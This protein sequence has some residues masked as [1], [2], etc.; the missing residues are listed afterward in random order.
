MLSSNLERQGVNLAIDAN[1]AYFDVTNRRVGVNTS[2]PNY[3]LDVNG[4]ANFGS[5]ITVLGVSTF[6]N[7]TAGNITVSG[8]INISGNTN[9]ITGN[10]GSFFGNAAGFGALYAGIS[11]GYVPDPQ[12]IQQST[13]NFNGYAGVVVGQNLNSGPFASADVFLSPD[14]GTYT[15]TYLDLGIA[16][17]Q[18][19]Y[20]G[21]SLIH[22]NDAYLYN[23]GNATT[24]GGN[25]ILGTGYNNDIVFA[26]DGIQPNNEVMRITRANVVAV[27]STVSSIS[28][29]TGAV[30]IAG[31][32]GVA[33][34]A[35]VSNVY[36]TNGVFWAANGVS[37]LYSNSN[38]ASYL[39]ANT[40]PTIVSLFDAIG[41]VAGNLSATTGNT[42]ILGANTVQAFVSNAVT[43]TSSTSVTNAIAELN[44]VLGKLVPPS[45]PNFPNNTTISVAT[46]NSGLMCNFA[47][48]DN[49]G[50]GNL[51]I[52]G[53]TFVN[54]VRASSF[55]T[56]GTAVTNV[57]PGSAGTVTVYV[58]GTP[59]GNVTLTGSNS[60]TTNGNLYIYN[61]QDYHNVVSTVTAGFWT[62]FSAY[63]T[64]GAGTLPGW[65]RVS[66][67]DSATGTSTNQATWYY[68]SSAPSVPA[69]TATSMVLSSNVVQYSST[70]P[71]FTTSA[72]FTLS[73]NVRNI[74]GDTY[75][76]STN[77]ISSS[78]A[79][80]AFAAP[81]LV[82]YAAA[83]VTTPITRSNTAY[84]YFSTT[85]NIASGFGNALG[86]SGPSI[87]VNNNYN[88]TAW[89]FSAPATY[90]LYKT[91]T[92]TQI[93]ETSL[94]I[95]GSVGS[96]SGNPYRIVNPDGG[97]QADT[98][99]YTGTE[100]AFN[101]TTGPF[102]QTDATNVA[103]KL[104]YD[105]TNYSS[106]FLPVGPNLSIRST[107]AQYFTFKF[108]R[109]A[110]SKFNIS[111]SG[112]I[113]GLWVALPGSTIDST[114]GLNGWLTMGTAYPG[115]GVPGTNG[116][117]NGSNGC[118][119]G[120]NAVFNSV[121]SSGS[122]TCTFGTVSSSSTATNEIYVRVKLTSGQSLTAL[123]IQAATN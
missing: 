116:G 83:G 51:S 121:V 73:G 45:P 78:N 82:S 72:G 46:T 122:Y 31:G 68:D 119:V 63:A 27:K 97:T 36:I 49:S 13:A 17:S 5:S 37:A 3:T 93:E 80:G 81:A 15:D 91:G 33:G 54:T 71:M 114:S 90:I 92:G 59:N 38:V 43:L 62:V 111:Y 69:F 105:V 50:W 53:G 56:S 58:N 88:S 23:W 113:A 39:A 8:N 123:S 96:G 98:P 103:A 95:A 109:S 44:Y 108:V 112:T 70:I 2:S 55:S 14:N 47:Q 1:V 24:G 77:L 94:T 32:L 9:T 106:G 102:Y 84:I 30:T 110:V 65:N 20:P 120:G 99:L 34:N 67:Y 35:Y 117:G 19:S 85:S 89:A 101:S 48:T 64:A 29:T 16:S 74:S 25:L 40:D 7:I 115:S 11:T 87:T 52:S 10:A 100:S 6:G 60:N 22:P 79:G 107:T 66:I 86:T 42:I 26:V 57:G 118:A 4:S 75:P 76:N 21:Y 61:V 18:Y 28:N 104:Q 41:N 12:T